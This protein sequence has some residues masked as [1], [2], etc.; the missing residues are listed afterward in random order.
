[1]LLVE[2]NIL[3]CVCSEK[4]RFQLFFINFKKKIMINY[5]K[6]GFSILLDKTNSFFSLASFLLARKTCDVA[7][8]H[9]SV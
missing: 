1:M 9:W 2:F 8:G 4:H 7:N 3:V 6:F 5:D